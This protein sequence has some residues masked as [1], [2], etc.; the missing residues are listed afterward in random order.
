VL[1]RLVLAI[2]VIAG[3]LVR[4]ADAG[5]Q[6]DDVECCCGTHGGDDPCGCP[7]CPAADH[8]GERPPADGMPR[9]K[10]C[11]AFGSIIAPAPLP[12][13]LAPAPQPP[14]RLPVRVPET[15]SPQPTPTERTLEP[16]TPPF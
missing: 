6:W 5:I 3:P 7:D 14:P 12:P 10:S 11:G 15:P 2:L 16:E 8:E 1:L 4:Y 9:A 13:A